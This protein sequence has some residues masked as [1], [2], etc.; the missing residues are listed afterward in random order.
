[1][2][3]KKVI[4]L[5]TTT[6]FI[7][8]LVL[9][10]IYQ[11][12]QKSEPFVLGAKIYYHEGNKEAKISM[13]LIED[14]RCHG[15]REFY[16]NVLPKIQEKYINPGAVSLTFVPVAF[17]PGSKPIANAAM[18]VSLLAPQQFFSFARAIFSAAQNGPLDQDAILQIAANVGGIDSHKLQNCMEK[19]C[20]FEEIDE[21]FEWARNL[22]KKN[23]HTPAIYING[24]LSSSA[25][26]ND[27]STRIEQL[28]KGQ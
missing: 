15:C 12:I 11:A 22:M 20:H 17:L 23:F 2:E 5:A 16:E 24:D 9:G 8:L 13:V 21:N 18:E 4:V 26:F 25:T 6:F 14:F 19:R 28:Q 10:I 3:G 7:G 1:M 27:V